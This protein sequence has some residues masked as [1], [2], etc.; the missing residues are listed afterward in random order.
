MKL[1]TWYSFIAFIH[2]IF[3]KIVDDM[4]DNNLLPKFKFLANVILQLITIYIIFFTKYFGMVWSLVIVIGGIGGM[5][6]ARDSI[7]APPW[8]LTIILGVLGLIYHMPNI[9]VYL[10]SIPNSNIKKIIYLILPSLVLLAISQVLE[11]KIFPEEFSRRKLFERLVQALVFLLC[12]INRT[13]IQHYFNLSNKLMQW[14][15]WQ[16][17]LGQGYLWTNIITM[18]ILMQ[19]N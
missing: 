13:K 12:I 2:G 19:K 17:W 6:L 18:L 3:F 15:I 1:A 7:S 9:K 14:I 16:T 4:Y 5:F 11:Q 10:S 8:I